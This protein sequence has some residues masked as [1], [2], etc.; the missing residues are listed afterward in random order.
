MRGDWYVVALVG[1]LLGGG[2][3][4]TVPR[5]ADEGGPPWYS[6]QGSHVIVETDLD[7]D[8]ASELVRDVEL[9]RQAM[10]VAVFPEARSPKKRLEVVALRNREMS[11]LVYDVSGFYS[12]VGGSSPI[13][14]LGASEASD[15]SEIMRHELAHAVIDEN[16]PGA[17][18]WLNEGL[19]ELLET[20]ELDEKTGEVTWG[21]LRRVPSG[22]TRY[23]LAPL[24]RLRDDTQWTPERR[25][26]LQYSAQF[27]VHMLARNHRGEFRCLLESLMDGDDVDG[28]VDGCF[29]DDDWGLEYSKELFQVGGDHVGTAKIDLPPA[30]P[31]EALAQRMAD[32]DVHEVLARVN[33]VAGRLLGKDDPRR[34]EL[35]AESERH[36]KRASGR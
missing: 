2:S 35:F 31:A 4:A 33:A 24:V 5:A 18:P 3:C 11:A 32:A 16:M 23:Q 10:T 14:L 30:P 17:P 27:L 34:E 22:Y 15:R 9:W 36:E 21:A 6:A 19:A 28:A 8:D 25:G 26:W 13:L 1:V 20:T 12:R 29:K 7:A